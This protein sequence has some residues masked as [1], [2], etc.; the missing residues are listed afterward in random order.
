MNKSFQRSIIG[1]LILLM[2]MGI[3]AISISLEEKE[4]SPDT[5]VPKMTSADI[6][7]LS[8]DE[9]KAKRTVAEGADDL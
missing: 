5:R 1:L 7:D 6:S 4:V 3:P 2:L 8:L 9:L